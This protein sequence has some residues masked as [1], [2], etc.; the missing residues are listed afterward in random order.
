MCAQENTTQRGHVY[1]IVNDWHRAGRVKIGMSDRDPIERTRELVSTGTTGIFVV[2]YDAEVDNP[3]YVEKAV[4][5]RLRNFNVGGEW[6]EVCPD[7]AAQEIRFV[8]GASLHREDTTPRWHRSLERAGEQPRAETMELLKEA[9]ERA[10]A[11]RKE[12][13]RLEA[14]AERERLWR[15]EEARAEQRR[16]EEEEARAQRQRDWEEASRRQQQEKEEA[17]ALERERRETERRQQLEAERLRRVR[18]ERDRRNK[19]LAEQAWRLVALAVPVVAVLLGLRLIGN[20]PR[21]KVARDVPLPKQEST[22]GKSATETVQETSPAPTKDDGDSQADR[23]PE[24]VRGDYNSRIVNAL[25]LARSQYEAGYPQAA[26]LSSWPFCEP[27]VAERLYGRK[28]LPWRQLLSIAADCCSALRKNA[29]NTGDIGKALNWQLK[30]AYCAHVLA[31]EH[32]MSGESSK[33]WNAFDTASE[34][35]K[36]VAS[37]GLRYKDSDR[38]RKSAVTAVAFALRN[39]AE[40]CVQFAEAIPLPEQKEASTTAQS[41]SQQARSLARECLVLRDKFLP[42]D[43]EGRDD[44]A[45][46]LRRAE[47]LP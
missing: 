23:V 6:F 8:A 16:K 18:E 20:L 32:M 4:H 7:R 36:R 5:Q 31:R 47:S 46:I 33:A 22:E 40:M 25:T 38:N 9:R 1:V 35:Y 11:Q 42:Q 39:N 37:E 27:D 41:L 43:I 2:I 26:I 14:E 34:I 24:V 3:S 29:V 19:L 10:E 13:A 15:E 28:L 44:V 12:Q 45:E 30:E 21:L 17:E